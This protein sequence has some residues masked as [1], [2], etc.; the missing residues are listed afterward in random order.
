MKKT[1]KY[2]KQKVYNTLERLCTSDGVPSSEV[3]TSFYDKLKEFEIIRKIR[4]RGNYGFVYKC[5]YSFNELKEKLILLCGIDLEKWMLLT[6]Q[7]T[8]EEVAAARETSKDEKTE[9]DNGFIWNI[10]H[11][12]VEYSYGGVESVA[13]PMYGLSVKTPDWR[14]FYVKDNV[15]I[16][17]I[18][19]YS[20]LYNIHKYGKLWDDGNSYLFVLR[21]ENIKKIIEWINNNQPHNE[22]FHFG[23]YDMSGIETYQNIKKEIINNERYHFFQLPVKIMDRLICQY[24]DPKLYAKQYRY[25]KVKRD[26][27]EIKELVAIINKYGKGLEQERFSN[28]LNDIT[29]NS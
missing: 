4:G 21:N 2:N 22:I 8:R 27:P 29:I 24:G 1:G 28:F 15:K 10:I 13:I 16:V 20:T 23:D 12:P 5:P 9:V 26:D 11:K 6:E 17:I 25:E 3:K 18:E 19:N 14:K 7:S